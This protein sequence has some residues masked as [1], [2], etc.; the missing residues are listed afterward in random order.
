MD[1]TSVV[2]YIREIYSK[3]EGFIAL[4]EPQFKGNEKKY[5][6]DAIDSTFVSSVGKY[7][8]LFEE[9]IA[10]F[11]GA[12][13]AVACVNGTNALHLALVLSGVENGDEVITQDLT[14]IATA[15]AI[16]Y[17]GA[18]PVFIDVDKD[19]PGLSPLALESWLTV[20]TE[21]KPYK[22]VFASFN[23]RTG[24]RIA[25][26]VPMHAFGH[27]CRMDEIMKVCDDFKVLVVEDAAESLGSYY[28]GK[29]TGT[30]SP[31][32][33]LSFNGNKIITTGGGGM[34]L[35]NDEDLAKK[36]KHLS[37]QAK[38]PHAWEFKHDEI[39]YN[40]RMPNVNAA[41]GLAQ[42]EQI[43][44]YLIKKRKLA[45][46]YLEFFSKIG[47]EF[48]KEPDYAKSNYWLN[49]LVFKSRMERDEFLKFTNENQLMTRPAWELMHTLPM[50]VSSQHDDLI[51]SQFWADRLVNIPSSVI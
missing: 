9:R 14:F 34:L 46:R 4:H 27:P 28:K 13:K 17:C 50:F 31:I 16:K 43:S 40:Y 32:G 3:P 36:A 44:E 23:R 29:H 6:L 7:V 38:I 8:D 39:A 45:D 37:T 10:N 49:A 18:E 1:Y 42:L 15:N 33:V 48:L 26:C 51:N 12:K 19:I 2:N 20:N 21:I 30:L 47:I 41:I 25:A 24:K 35:F 5:V 11:T 22:G